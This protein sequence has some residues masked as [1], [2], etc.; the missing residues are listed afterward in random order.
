[1]G[2]RTKLLSFRWLRRT[3]SVHSWAPVRLFGTRGGPAGVYLRRSFVFLFV[4]P[5][6]TCVTYS[7]LWVRTA[8]QEKVKSGNGFS[9][10]GHP[11]SRPPGIVTIFQISP[12]GSRWREWSLGHSKKNALSL[13]TMRRITFVIFVPHLSFMIIISAPPL[14]VVFGYTYSMNPA[15]PHVLY[16]VDI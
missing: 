11:F 5:F 1:M 14:S 3:I 13:G 10:A 12:P 6:Y 2:N 4:I 16:V 9:V 8:H 15:L 7:G